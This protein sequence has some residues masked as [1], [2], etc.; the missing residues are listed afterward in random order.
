MSVKFLSLDS[1]DIED[2]KINELV[3]MINIFIM[4]CYTTKKQILDPGQKHAS[5]K[6]F[7]L[8]VD[9]IEVYKNPNFIKI[10]NDFNEEEE[11]EK[12]RKEF[13]QRQRNNAKQFNPSNIFANYW[14]HDNTSRDDSSD[15]EQNRTDIEEDESLQT[16]V[17]NMLDESYGVINNH[18]MLQKI[19]EVTRHYK[20]KL[21]DPTSDDTSD[22]VGAKTELLT[23]MASDP[24]TS[25]NIT[26]S[27]EQTSV[28]TST[29]PE[30]NN[31]E[32]R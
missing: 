21:L 9:I 18:S 19:V 6:K 17:S 25:T 24:W 1:N 20:C 11:R 29:A 13:L 8:L 27:E 30:D 14:N 10:I 12:K 7:K 28:L 32:I 5:L 23:R 2:T 16:D 15:D 3:S 26:G 22:D 31:D 4:E